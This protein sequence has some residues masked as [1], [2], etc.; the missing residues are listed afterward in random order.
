[1]FTGLLKCLIILKLYFSLQFRTS[2]T[3]RNGLNLYTLIYFTL[4]WSF[5]VTCVF[6][7]NFTSCFTN[8][9]MDYWVD[10]PTN[11][12]VEMD[13]CIWHLFRVIWYALTLFHFNIITSLLTSSVACMKQWQFSLKTALFV[14]FGS[15]LAKFW[16][17]LNDLAIIITL[18]RQTI[19]SSSHRLRFMFSTPGPAIHRRC[20]FLIFSL[21]TEGISS[22]RVIAE[23]ILWYASWNNWLKVCITWFDQL[24]G[25]FV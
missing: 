20:K 12:L 22:I 7:L 1:M 19:L 17:S 23:R 18:E 2:S 8:Q 10:R 14:R 9:W 4:Y 16:P 13:E 15:I 3:C 6:C 5:T 24:W 25:R 21:T 11:F